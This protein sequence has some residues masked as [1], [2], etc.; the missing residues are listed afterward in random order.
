M[1]EP[2]SAASVV[3]VH[4]EYCLGIILQ[5]IVLYIIHCHASCEA[6]KKKLFSLLHFKAV[7]QR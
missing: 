3:T 6:G 7:L 5:I 2:F 4:A 1:W